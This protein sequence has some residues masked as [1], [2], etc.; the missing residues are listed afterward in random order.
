VIGTELLYILG[1]LSLQAEW[2]W[3]SANDTVVANPS[4][5]G[6][7]RLALGDAWFDGGYVQLSYF[8]TGENRRYDRRWGRLS[9]NSIGSPFTPFWLTRGEDGNMLFGRG[10]WE[11]AARYSHLNLNNG[12][13]GGGQTDAYELGV[14]W[15]LNA[16]FRIEFEYLHQLRYQKSTGPFGTLPGDIDGLGIRTQLMF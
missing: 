14:N 12:P 10:A 13:I 9:R 5:V 6:P 8:L 3:G 2:T 7:R 15:Y 16:N 11:L 4:R 1:P